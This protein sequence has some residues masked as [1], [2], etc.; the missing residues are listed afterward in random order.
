MYINVNRLSNIVG[1]ANNSINNYENVIYDTISTLKNMKYSWNDGYT[2]SF[3]RNVDRQINYVGY[4]IDEM[5]EILRIIRYISNSYSNLAR[6]IPNY[7]GVINSDNF[8][9][10]NTDSEDYL[11]NLNIQININNIEDTIASIIARDR[12][13]NISMITYNNL[14]K[15]DE[16]NDFIGMQDNMKDEIKAFD[17][18]KNNARAYAD[19]VINTLSIDTGTYNSSNYHK[20]IN[21]VDKLSYD[22]NIINHSLDNAYNY[23]ISRQRELKKLV[24]DLSN[25]VNQIRFNR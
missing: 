9:I 2:N 6:Y 19:S 12:N 1:S 23:I 21:L 10:G 22:V 8:N 3:F 11:N 16:K 18:K 4:I 5:N 14:D 25:D 13:S 17:L 24:S 20:I 15:V 7:N